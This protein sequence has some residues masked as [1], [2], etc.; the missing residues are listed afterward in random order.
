MFECTNVRGDLWEF[1]QVYPT[2]NENLS[3]V[4]YRT[5]ASALQQRIGLVSGG[6]SIGLA[7]SAA[8]VFSL[9]YDRVSAEA[10]EIALASL[11]L[12]ATTQASGRK[13]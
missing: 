5:R 13:V 8:Y 12:D 11:I 9:T 6:F 10:S 2:W 3:Q 1:R 7:F 4:G